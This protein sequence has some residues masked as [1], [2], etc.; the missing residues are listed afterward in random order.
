M[1]RVP[2]TDRGAAPGEAIRRAWAAVPSPLS[3]PPR[4]PVHGRPSC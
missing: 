3:E 1:S 4:A 2:G